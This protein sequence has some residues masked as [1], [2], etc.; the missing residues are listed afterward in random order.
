LADGAGK[1]NRYFVN[2]MLWVLRSVERS[3]TS[4]FTRWAKEGI[5]E[6]VFESLTGDPDNP[7]LT[8]IP[9][10]TEHWN[11]GLVRLVHFVKAEPSP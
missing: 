2:A 4:T 8:G 9:Q 3:P 6:R 10:M 5:C 1:D 11:L 7:Y